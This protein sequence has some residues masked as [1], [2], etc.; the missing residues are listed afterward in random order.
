MSLIFEDMALWAGFAFVLASPGLFSRRSRWLVAAVVFANALDTF[1][2]ILP[3]LDHQFHLFH[4]HWNWNGKLF[5]VCAMAALAALLVA[6]GSFSR[7]DIGLTLRQAPGSLRAA[8]LVAIPY[9]LLL[10]ALNVFFFGNN[11]PPSLETTLYQATMPGLAEELSIRGV[12]FALFDRIL[13]FRV[14]L[15]GAEIG[16]G[17]IATS[18]WFGLGHA[19]SL[20]AVPDWKSGL[21]AFGTTGAIGFLLAWLRARTKSLVAPVVVHNITNLILEGVPRL[22]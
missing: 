13:T 19:V 8:L 17:A 5:S 20:D 3:T 16:Y 12:Q 10:A 1:A 11:H 6:S 14:Q 21:A 4:G 22:F 18:I 7:R 2:T 15:A 9:F